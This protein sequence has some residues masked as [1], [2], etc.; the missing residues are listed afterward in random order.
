MPIGDTIMIV[1][2]G[3][4]GVL[5][6]KA[7][8]SVLSAYQGKTLKE[9]LTGSKTTFTSAKDTTKSS[10]SVKGAVSWQTGSHGSSCGTNT[11]CTGDL[12]MDFTDA[13]VANADS[14]FSSDTTRIRLTTTFANS[15]A[16]TSNGH[17]FGGI[18]GKHVQGSWGAVYESAPSY[19]YCSSY[20]GYGSA[21]GNYAGNG[22]AN[23]A[24]QASCFSTPG[25]VE[26]RVDFA[27]YV[28]A[29]DAVALIS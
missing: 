12:F 19:P 20:N 28:N 27:I 23:N 29:G 6:G 8:Y 4:N 13:L 5:L 21:N 18:G 24:F 14:G 26:H 25:G 3:D 11:A 1:A 16:Q 9:L 22:V 2:R 17:W 15:P 10:G 7:V